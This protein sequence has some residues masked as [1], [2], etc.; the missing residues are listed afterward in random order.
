MGIAYV[1]FRA[2]AISLGFSFLAFLAPFAMIDMVFFK[3][4]MIR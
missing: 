2:M 4:G 1:L 3:G